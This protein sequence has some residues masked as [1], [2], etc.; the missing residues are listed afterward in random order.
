[1][2]WDNSSDVFGVA[3]YL[4]RVYYNC[5]NPSVFSTCTQVYPST[6][7]LWL[8]ASQYQAGTTA[9]G[10]YYWQV[11]AQDNAGNQSVWSDVENVTIDTIAP[12]AP[13]PLTPT[14][15]VVLGPVAFTQTWT[16][17]AGAVEYRYQSCSVDPGDL[18]GTCSSIKYTNTYPGTTKAVG[19]GQ[20]DSHFWWRVQAR[21][22]AGNWSNYGPAYE[23]TI[24][25]TAPTDPT[26]VASNTHTPSISNSNNVIGMAWSLAGALPGAT[27][28]IS[29]VE[30][31]S[32]SFTTSALDLPDD[33]KDLD[34]TATGVVSP[35]LADGTW[36]FHLRTLDKAGHWTSTV[37]TGPYIVDTSTPSQS[38]SSSSSSGG[39]VLGSST[40]TTC[41]DSKPAA[42]TLLVAQALS[43]SVL[44]TWSEGSGPL[45]YYLVAY[46]TSPGTPLYG[47][48]NIG[49]P[50]TT[51]YLVE[52]LSGGTTY[53]FQVRSGNG[54][55]TGDF[56]GQLQATPTGGFIA[57]PATG[58][59]EEV[60]GVDTEEESDS[61]TEEIVDTELVK[62]GGVLGESDLASGFFWWYL[63]IPALLLGLLLLWKRRKTQDH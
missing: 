47:N 54:C 51:S 15:G 3:G 32:Y 45:T 13:T 24:D 55:A 17:V 50:G 39:S 63:L 21:D 34:E 12:S 28:A 22:A 38:T 19:A 42:P 52:G 36:Y 33:I 40:S 2:Q 6:V 27:D 14:D 9:D 7:G 44:L 5:T 37:H 23:L 8:T 26:D 58:F 4:Y 46:G 16:S 25:A 31:Y 1:M 48:P 43:N 57:E 29:G 49:G 62:Q 18:G 56:S 61:N 20:P 35:T 60:L 11:R 41:T 53:Y 10:V 59:E 30:G